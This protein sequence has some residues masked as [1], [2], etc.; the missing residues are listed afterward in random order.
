VL[1]LEFGKT[2]SKAEAAS[3]LTRPPRE[4]SVSLA[5]ATP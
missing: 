2:M 3:L 5:V 1:R 4:K